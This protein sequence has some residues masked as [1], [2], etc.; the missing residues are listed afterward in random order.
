MMHVSWYLLDKLNTDNQT[1]L[2]FVSNIRVSMDKLHGAASPQSVR[3]M[4]RKGKS[5]VWAADY[6]KC[7]TSGHARVKLG[8]NCVGPISQN[9]TD[10]A[11]ICSFSQCTW[12]GYSTNICIKTRQRGYLYVPLYG[13]LII[14]VSSPVLMHNNDS[15]QMS[16]SASNVLLNIKRSS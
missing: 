10:S 6:V 16:C 1:N 7:I 3:K 11:N 9:L 4:P 5:I 13:P 15:Y 12:D 8:E 14:H 2:S